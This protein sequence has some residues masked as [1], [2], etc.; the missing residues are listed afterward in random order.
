MYIYRWLWRRKHLSWW[1]HLR[2]LWECFGDHSRMFWRRFGDV[3][4]T[5]RT[6]T[7]NHVLLT[8]RSCFAHISSAL[9]RCF[10][11]FS[12][13]FEHV[14]NTFPVH[15]ADISTSLAEVPGNFGGLSEFRWFR[16]A[17]VQSTFRGRVEHV[18]QMFDHD[19]RARFAD[20]RSTFRWHFMHF[21]WRFEQLRAA[22]GRFADVLSTFCG[23]FADISKTCGRRFTE[24]FEHV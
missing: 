3:S 17:D 23:C 19:F 12:R 11:H 8:F 10:E 18:S 5:F 15:F 22:S 2:T 16:F 7:F 20:V 4:R 14:S 6:Y 21:G 24:R 13:C 9:R 1:A